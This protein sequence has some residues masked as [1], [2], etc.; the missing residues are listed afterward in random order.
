MSNPMTTPDRLRL[1]IAETLH[2]DAQVLQETIGRLAVA[3][4]AEY[5]DADVDARSVSK[6]EAGLTVL[7]ADRIPAGQEESALAAEITRHHGRTAAQ[8]LLGDRANELLG[9]EGN[10]ESAINSSS[11]AM[12]DVST[13]FRIK[14]LAYVQEWNDDLLRRALERLD[15]GCSADDALGILQKAADCLNLSVLRNGDD[16]TKLQG[17]QVFGFT[18]TKD[19]DDYVSGKVES[20]EGAQ[21]TFRGSKPPERNGVYKLADGR[22]SRFLDGQWR[23]PDADAQKAATQTRLDAF[24]SPQFRTKDHHRWIDADVSAQGNV[25][26]VAKEAAKHELQKA[27]KK[28]TECGLLDDLAGVLHPDA[29]NQF[30]DAVDARDE[31]EKARDESPSPGM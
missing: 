29:I 31:P 7:L 1:A 23:V 26:E 25:Q 19:F 9:V 11:N 27:L 15:P 4:S 14:R 3:T 16:A 13:D 17:V 18:T 5:P 2:V 30:C 21:A 20:A 24:P 28:A 10:V 6:R 12:A 8:A 22:F